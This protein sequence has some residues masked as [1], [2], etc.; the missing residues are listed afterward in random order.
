MRRHWAAPTA[1]SASSSFLRGAGIKPSR[2]A[3]LRAS[4]RAR[5]IASLFSR[6]VYLGG[7]FVESAT[8]HLAENAFPLHLPLKRPESL[9]DVV[10]TDKYLQRMLP[11]VCSKRRACRQR[12]PRR[13]NGMGASAAH[14]PRDRRMLLTDKTGLPDFSAMS[15]SCSS[16]TASAGASPSRPPRISLGTLRLDR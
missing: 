8:L 1:F 5:R 10:I 6:A 3:R 12:R 11:S 15:R 2:C 4:L 9:I 7:L 13:L 16:I 14:F